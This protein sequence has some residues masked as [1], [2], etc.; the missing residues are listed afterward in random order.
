ME[1]IYV[2]MSCFYTN[3]SNF[4]FPCIGYS[5]LYYCDYITEQEKLMD[6]KFDFKIGFQIFKEGTIELSVCQ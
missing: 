6:G 3:E 2:Y 5:C 4:A 1:Y